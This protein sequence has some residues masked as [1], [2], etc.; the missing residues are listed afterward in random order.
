MATPN[1][2]LQ[3][4]TYSGCGHIAFMF[5]DGRRVL[6]HKSDL[7]NYDAPDDLID[8]M[9]VMLIKLKMRPVLL[10]GTKTTEQKWTIIQNAIKSGVSL[11]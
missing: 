5:E 10:D 7:L 1:P 3:A 8:A 6:L 2:T 4:A 9:F 11:W